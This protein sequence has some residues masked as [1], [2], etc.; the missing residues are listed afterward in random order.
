LWVGIELLFRAFESSDQ[1]LRFGTQRDAQ[2][3][4]S[5]QT[6]MFWAKRRMTNPQARD[7]LGAVGELEPALD[8]LPKYGF[9]ATEQ[10][11]APR[12]EG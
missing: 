6:N 4:K 7:R 3:S 9:E 5:L 10:T 11:L 8:S 1:R 12:P 2:Q